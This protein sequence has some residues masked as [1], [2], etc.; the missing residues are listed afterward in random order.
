M[1][2]TGTIGPTLWGLADRLAL[3]H[4][5]SSHA[6]VR[7]LS[8]TRVPPEVDTLYLFDPATVRLA[9]TI[10]GL[11]T[12]PGRVLDVGTDDLGLL[13]QSAWRRFGCEV[14]ALDVADRCV[15]NA[16]RCCALNGVPVSVRRSDSFRRRAGGMT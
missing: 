1:R 16:V 7:A 6:L 12:T 8:G 15:E 2:T 4:I 9:A 5:F 14:E 10:R 11:R 3:R 13:A